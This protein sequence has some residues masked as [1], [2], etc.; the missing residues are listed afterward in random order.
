MSPAA[1]LGKENSRGCEAH[2]SIPV[3]FWGVSDGGIR[4][5]INS[6]LQAPRRAEIWAVASAIVRAVIRRRWQDELFTRGL[7][8]FMRRVMATV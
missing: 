6:N 8:E 2:I 1:T 3:D 5:N 7:I 4:L